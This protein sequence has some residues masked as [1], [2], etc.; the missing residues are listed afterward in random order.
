MMLRS[1]KMQKIISNHDENY[2][3]YLYQLIYSIAHI[4]HHYQWL[5]T[6]FEAYPQMKIYQNLLMQNE[7]LI[8][9]TEQ[10]LEMLKRDNFQWIWGIFSAIPSQYSE[11][12]I[13]NYPLPNIKENKKTTIQHPLAEIEIGAIDSSSLYIISDDTYIEIFKKLYPCAQ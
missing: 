3:T 7:Y 2:Y 10:F 6:D 1:K 11:E 5:I 13:L 8:L 12:E 9:S 4:N